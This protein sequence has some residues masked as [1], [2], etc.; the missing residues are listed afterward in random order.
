MPEGNEGEI[1]DEYTDSQVKHDQM[2]FDSTGTP[3]KDLENSSLGDKQRTQKMFMNVSNDF[4]QVRHIQMLRTVIVQVEHVQMLEFYI[5]GQ[6]IFIFFYLRNQS[7][8][9]LRLIGVKLYPN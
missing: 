8:L 5:N 9:S 7:Q 6:A 2:L 3:D 1:G 4:R